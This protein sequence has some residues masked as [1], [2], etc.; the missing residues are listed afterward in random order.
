MDRS[1]G[2]QSSDSGKN[3]KRS[4]IS[5]MYYSCFPALKRI[6]VPPPDHAATQQQADIAPDQLRRPSGGVN[7]A[8]TQHEA[9]HGEGTQ[10]HTNIEQL[11]DKHLKEATK[12]Y[13]Q[14]NRLLSEIRENCNELRKYNDTDLDQLAGKIVEI[15]D[16]TSKDFDSR[17]QILQNAC[18]ELKNAGKWLEPLSKVSQK[19]RERVT[20]E[21]DEHLVSFRNAC[22]ELRK[23]KDQLEALRDFSHVWKQTNEARTQL[24]ADFGE[25]TDR[26][27]HHR[28]KELA[29][30]VENRI[31]NAFNETP[32]NPWTLQNAHDELRK[33]KDQLDILRSANEIR[34]QI[35]ADHS[36]AT[37]ENPR[38]IKELSNK[39]GNNLEKNFNIQ[40]DLWRQQN[41]W[42]ELRKLKVLKDVSDTW[43]QAHEIEAKFIGAL[44]EE[45]QDAA[46]K[47]IKMV[48][49]TFDSF[50]SSFE[51][52]YSQKT[53][54]PVES[55]KEAPSLFNNL[56]HQ[57]RLPKNIEI[58]R[59]QWQT[60]M[61]RNCKNLKLLVLEDKWNKLVESREI[62]LLKDQK[63]L[64]TSM[65]NKKAI[66]TLEDQFRLA[67]LK[68]DV[69]NA[70]TLVN[71]IAESVLKSYEIKAKEVN[72][73]R[74]TRMVDSLRTLFDMR[75]EHRPERVKG[76]V[77][78]FNKTLGD[79]KGKLDAVP[80]EV[81]DKLVETTISIMKDFKEYY[82]DAVRGYGKRKGRTARE[83]G[84][85]KIKEL[86]G[87]LNTLNETISSY[88]QIHEIQTEV[89][90]D[91][92]DS[93][94][95]DAKSV[96]NDA[97]RTFKQLLNQRENW[98]SLKERIEGA[99]RT[100]T[101]LVKTKIE[102]KSEE[103]P[104]NKRIINSEGT[105]T[106]EEDRIIINIEK[107]TIPKKGFI[108]EISSATA[109]GEH[110][111]NEDS[112]F[113][114]EYGSGVFD[115]VSQ[116]GRGAEASRMTKGI[117][118]RELSKL[119]DKIKSGEVQTEHINDVLKQITLDANNE[120]NNKLNNEIQ[121]ENNNN[122]RA[123][124]TLSVVM[125][126]GD[127]TMMAVNVGDSR[128]YVLT[129]A[130]QLKHITTD[131]GILSSDK[132]GIRRMEQ[133]GYPFANVLANSIK[134][135]KLSEGEQKEIQ[136]KVAKMSE[137]DIK[138][139]KTKIE[140]NYDT[141]KA[142]SREINTVD[143]ETGLMKIN[144]DWDTIVN[145]ELIDKGK[146]SLE[147][148]KMGLVIM[149]GRY[150]GNSLGDVD[151]EPNIVT[152][153]VNLGDRV[154]I[155]SDGV[156]DNL[157]DPDIKDCMSQCATAEEAAQ[158]LVKTAIEKSLDGTRSR[159]KQ[160]DDTTVVVVEC[161]GEGRN[162][163]QSSD[164]VTV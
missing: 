110:N 57:A 134:G 25:A 72:L 10:E 22:D 70:S 63:D 58:I 113:V 142:R 8:R 151:T 76:I 75:R 104:I 73:S 89:V 24:E 62:H 108:K 111:L 98:Q 124:T 43:K 2:S 80:E 41:V 28:I 7:E 33:A 9:G 27:S 107:F 77:D 116:G 84:E 161:S 122:E 97:D 119:S 3:S 59:D 105:I 132:E 127:R 68:D 44:S 14:T 79:M 93:K 118:E 131:D 16:N 114:S 87:Q 163:V 155:T 55:K 86:N 47:R 88:K 94:K 137:N 162:N 13:E 126:I 92:W 90:E 38:R 91:L 34:T 42:N 40:N 15:S 1:S 56:D 112:C 64:T 100:L 123:R 133:E 115:G 125:P 141:A 121:L 153:D 85:E 37:S 160:G 149:Y 156:H 144:K 49:R 164:R 158:A 128:V 71:Q 32:D 152:F 159:R 138:E 53:D 96:V 99:H 69:A 81:K 147:E 30:D 35:E 139:F 82:D 102:S 145:E 129:K 109:K 74:R 103:V 20:E 148:I 12:T 150:I 60:S 31:K 6:E 46:G 36:E 17:S 67:W 23:T 101:D 66:K 146:L 157:S 26:N 117:L 48:D 21:I 29:K 52:E 39:I 18:N 154:I 130:G 106:E 19:A 45:F 95:G 136:E 54:R 120:I 5:R 143:P 50:L 83:G 65:R 51:Q 61:E 78:E 11:V 140:S 4:K 135:N